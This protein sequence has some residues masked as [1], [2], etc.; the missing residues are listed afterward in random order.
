M[1][2]LSN[3]IFQTN[4]DV[5]T[6]IPRPELSRLISSRWLQVCVQIFQQNTTRHKAGVRDITNHWNSLSQPHRCGP[7]LSPQIC[8][9]RLD[10]KSSGRSIFNDRKSPP[11]GLSGPTVTP[12]LLQPR[13]PY[14]KTPGH[15]TPPPPRPPPL[16]GT[17][18]APSRPFPS[19]FQ[20]SSRT[21]PPPPHLPLCFRPP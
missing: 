6:C 10:H 2:S 20:S 7:K 9:T 14:S 18:D 11:E 3:T 15:P 19:T 5:L 17:T 8:D 4:R 13:V 1:C 12:R 16:Q 21:L